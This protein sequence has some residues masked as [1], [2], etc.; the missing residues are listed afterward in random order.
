MAAEGLKYLTL[1][2]GEPILALDAVHVLVAAASAHGVAAFVVSSGAWAR[3]LDTARRVVQRAGAVANWDLGV[4][5]WHT[6][7][8]P[9]ERIDY[10]LTA[11][12]ETGGTATVRICDSP[13]ATEAARIWNKVN[14]VVRGRAAILRQSV[15]RIGRGVEAIASKAGG[16]GT[17][18]RRPCVSTGLFVRADGSTGP[19]CSGLAYE[20]RDRHPFT[21]GEI[22][23]PGALMAAWQAWRRD[24]L[25]RI[26]RLA[27]LAALEGWL[28]DTVLT[29]ARFP[30]DPCE[31]CVALWSRLA[32]AEARYVSAR[33]KAPDVA[34]KLDLLE[35]TLEFSFLRDVH[36]GE[37]CS[38]V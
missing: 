8:M 35:A 4:D 14:T 11:I 18:P 15:R 27:S 30:E 2:G 36:D 20:A 12:L 6:A 28:P 5:G 1:T 21:Y 33:A 24:P 13:D 7:Q 17:L 9:I 10:A 25:L 19:C 29:E 16:G 23:R 3:T 37:V 26:M 38:T 22:R 32:P 31:A 34:T